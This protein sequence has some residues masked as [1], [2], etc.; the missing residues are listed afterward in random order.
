MINKMKFVVPSGRYVVAVSGGVDSVTLLH[1]LVTAE[2][3]NEKNA[4]ESIS[5]K[6]QSQTKYDVD[7]TT[8]P[9]SR[10]LSPRKQRRGVELVVAHLDHGIREESAED[11]KF[12]QKLAHAYGLPYI[13][14]RAEL[15]PTA[16]EAAA[17]EARY[18]FLHKVRKATKSNAI[19]TAHHEDDVLETIVL[20][21]QRG[22][23]NRGLCSLRSTDTVL[24]PLLHLKKSD[25]KK[26][27][28]ANK[29]EWREDDTN[30]INTYS[31]NHIRNQLV[32]KLGR[33][34]RSLLLKCGKRAEELQREIDELTARHLHLQPDTHELDRHGF[35]MLPHALAREIMAA[36]LKC[37]TSID[38]SSKMLE[39]LV[40]AAKTGRIG[41][42]ID[43]ANGYSLAI[44][45]KRVKLLRARKVD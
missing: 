29:L 30:L 6:N 42:R 16:S 33:T 5:V 15:G 37:R 32:P 34:R 21:L 22:T 26:Y 1:I 8:N 24:R 31:R 7:N 9:F 3:G 43:I 11:R 40:V 27:A 25:I 18:N 44:E 2:M 19:I 14:E 10:G 17:R 41:S 20:N 4:N 28:R 12:V 38:I 35:T 23:G 36:W 39:R 45:A 13:Y